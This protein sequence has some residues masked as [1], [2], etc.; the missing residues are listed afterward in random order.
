MPPPL[1]STTLPTPLSWRLAIGAV[2]VGLGFFAYVA[3]H[4][5]GPHGQAACGL[6]CFIG[7]VAALSA[8]LRAINWRTLTWGFGLQVFLALFVNKFA[9]YGLSGLGIPDGFKPGYEFFRILTD[10]IKQLLAF[11]DAG[12]TFVFGKL[13]D[14][15]TM[16]AVFPGG[17]VFAFVALPTIIFIAS[18]FSVLYYFGVLQWVVRIMARAMTY[19]LRTSGAE[20]L[21]VSANVFMGQTEAPLIIRPYVA[22]MTRSELLTMMV[23]GM[24]HISGGL[25]AVYIGLGADAVAILT[26]SV[27]AAPGTLYL[28][29]LFLPELEEPATRGVVKTVVEQHHVNVIDAASSGAAEG[30]RL[31]LNI[32]AMLIAFLA[33][34]A[35]FDYLLAAGAIGFNNTCAWL[36][37]P[38]ELPPLSLTQLFSWIFSP[39]AV[40]M[41]VQD[42]DLSRMGDLL[43][44]KLAANE[45]VAYV[46]FKEYAATLS[47]RT[48][49]LATY[50][51]TGFANFSSIG[52]QIGG[53]GAMAPSRR[54]DLARLGGRALFVGFIVTLIN[55]S[56]AG[57]LL[58]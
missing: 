52:I 56:L 29:K 8:N 1:T 34:I 14:P 46:R 38:W 24:A 33:F 21:S 45:F 50:A 17:Y 25:M 20:T 3:R 10:D 40:L 15:N 37:V 47:P 35:L 39:V 27:M 9:L 5:I 23:G 19:L 36:G 44:T 13:A 26:T 57:I 55:A 31:A 4:A 53:I 32:A 43:G 30:L 42:S 7:I 22:G 11:T 16:K 2:V 41:G 54:H 51:L 49:V 6:V 48:Q 58:D 12:S 28:S 18:F